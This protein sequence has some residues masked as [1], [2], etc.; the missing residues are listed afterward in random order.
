M[1]THYNL[2]PDLFDL[3]ASDSQEA[4]SPKYASLDAELQAEIASKP[5]T[6]RQLIDT[7]PASV[8]GYD[9]IVSRNQTWTGDLPSDKLKAK[10][11][12]KLF[13]ELRWAN[14]GWV[15]QVRVPRL[16]TSGARL[17][18]AVVD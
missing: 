3:Y 12:E 16:C 10:T 4:I 5:H 8:L 15:Y 9:E 7:E 11:A 14:L 18:R 17:T 13:K 2:P 1:S 6:V